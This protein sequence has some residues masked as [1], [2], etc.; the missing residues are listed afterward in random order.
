MV[1]MAVGPLSSAERHSELSPARALLEGLLHRRD[2]LAF[3]GVLGQAAADRRA[4][5]GVG[6]GHAHDA[7]G[8][9]LEADQ[10]GIKGPRELR[11]QIERGRVFCRPGHCQN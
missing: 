7:I 1:P 10:L 9:R 4:H 2:A 11:G 5:A 8:G 3:L 6:P